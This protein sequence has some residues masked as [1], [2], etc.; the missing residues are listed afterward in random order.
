MNLLSLDEARRAVVVSAGN[1]LYLVECADT[2]RLERL[3]SG[4]D[5]LVGLSEDDR[6]LAHAHHRVLKAV[7]EQGYA[8]AAAEELEGICSA[9]GLAE[10]RRDCEPILDAALPPWSESPSAA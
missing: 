3:L 6:A 7:G 5:E 1:L 9:V 2:H 8:W 10:G 4:S